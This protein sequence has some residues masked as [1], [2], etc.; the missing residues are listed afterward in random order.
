MVTGQY[1]RYDEGRPTE[2]IKVNF[3]GTEYRYE[4]LNNSVGIPSMVID[5]QGRKYTLCK[6]QAA[7]EKTLEDLDAEAEAFRANKKSEEI[8][9]KAMSKKYFDDIKI[10]NNQINNPKTKKDVP[11]IYDGLDEKYNYM[12][13]TRYFTKAELDFYELFIERK[14][15]VIAENIKNTGDKYGELND[16]SLNNYFNT[17]GQKIELPKNCKSLIF[18][19]GEYY[20][21]AVDEGYVI[22]GKIYNLKDKLIG[23][24]EEDENYYII[25]NVKLKRFSDFDWVDTLHQIKAEKKLK[26]FNMADN[27]KSFLYDVSKGK[28]REGSYRAIWTVSSKESKG[29]IINAM[30]SLYNWWNN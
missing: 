9:F 13:T 21:K 3:K 2:I 19:E 15:K 5:A 28:A 18:K 6:S 26:Y 12:S 24:L 27:N 17:N 30:V 14:N 23:K 20:K 22:D 8:A 7:K 25:N 11:K 10:L 4:L 29:C 16:W 1:D